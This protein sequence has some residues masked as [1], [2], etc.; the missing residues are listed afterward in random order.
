[1]LVHVHRP[2]QLQGVIVQKECKARGDGVCRRRRAAGGA[3]V[4]M[5]QPTL[6]Q[7]WQET[8][9]DCSL[10]IE[11]YWQGLSSP[12]PLQRGMRGLTGGWTNVCQQRCKQNAGATN[13]LHT[14]GCSVL[15]NSF[16]SGRAATPTSR[17]HCHTS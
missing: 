17:G 5:H 3:R 13:R 2:V 7:C 10:S 12:R 11:R 8:V 4:V 16:P 15:N 9:L 1:M 14:D 6:E